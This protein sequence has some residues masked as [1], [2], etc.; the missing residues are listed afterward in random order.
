MYLFAYGTLMFADVWKRIGIVQF[1]SQ[2][3][4]LSGFAIYR[5]RGALIP[6]IIRTGPEDQVQ[7]ILYHGLDEATLEE[8]D[9]YESDLYQR[10]TVHARGRDSELFECQTYVIPVANRKVLSAEAWDADWFQQHGLAQ[11]LRG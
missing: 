11:Y 5:I 3:A 8:L 2:P 1:A 10:T 4:T 6:G 7:G 9:V